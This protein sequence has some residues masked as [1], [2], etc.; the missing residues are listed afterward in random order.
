MIAT[1]LITFIEATAISFLNGY[2]NLRYTIM[3][4]NLR[5]PFEEEF[6]SLCHYTRLAQ[7]PDREENLVSTQVLGISKPK[8]MK[9]T[10]LSPYEFFTTIQ[11]LQPVSYTHLTL[12]TTPYV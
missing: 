9:L 10:A 8:N 3:T 5:T 7:T 2:C 11:A 1:S 6:F 4:K 12:P